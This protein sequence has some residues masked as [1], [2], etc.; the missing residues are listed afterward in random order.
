M[1]QILAA[2]EEPDEGPAL[3][4]HMIADRALQHWKLSFYSIQDRAQRHWPFDLK[5][6]LLADISQS[7]QVMRENHS[8]H[9]SISTSAGG[10]TT[11]IIAE[12]EPRPIAQLED[13][14]RWA[15]SYRRSSLRHTP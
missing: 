15:P 5:L 6:N 2:G 12:S 3:L 14:G 9:S 11:R 7:P 10:R 8:D 4:R 1:R 13:P